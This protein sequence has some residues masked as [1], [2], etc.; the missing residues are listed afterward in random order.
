MKAT[1]DGKPTIN[2]N[3]NYYLLRN[4]QQGKSTKYLGFEKQAKYILSDK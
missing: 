3:L 4:T 2:L 1:F